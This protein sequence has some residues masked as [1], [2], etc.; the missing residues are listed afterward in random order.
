MV[1]T[2]KVAV[3]YPIGHR[4]RRDGIPVLEKFKASL[5][6]RFPA[7]QANEIFKLCTENDS[8][9]QMPVDSFMDKWVI[10]DEK[11]VVMAAAFISLSLN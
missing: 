7:S 6:K 10:N 9:D 3:E 11:A 4:N 2:E 5:S 8:F 1:K